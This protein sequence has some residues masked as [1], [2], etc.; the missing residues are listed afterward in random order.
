MFHK[1]RKTV[2]LNNENELLTGELTNERAGALNY[3]KIKKCIAD[4]HINRNGIIY[5]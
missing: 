3:E 2:M 5:K 1:R 4:H